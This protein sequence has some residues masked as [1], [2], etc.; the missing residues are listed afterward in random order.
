MKKLEYVAILIFLAIVTIAPTCVAQT[1]KGIDKV[2]HDI[3]YYRESRITQP[4]VKV[5]YGRPSKSEQAVFGDLV[6]YGE[7]WRT[8]YNEATEVQFYK[9]VQFGDKKV[10][11]G[12]YVLITIPG[13]DEW[14]VILNSQ[15]DTWGAFQYD[16]IF[17]VAEIT[18]PSS[19]AE[20]LETFSIAFKRKSEKIQMV[21]G[22]DT[23]RVTIPLQF[24]GNTNRLAQRRI[25]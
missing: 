17:N 16:P 18:V 20:E 13:E 22:W 7:V 14:K 8:G 24:K 4:L 5:L 11:A 12:T 19:K 25:H 2:P 3:S 1:F 6:P 23:T 10:A 15:L 21:L 9:D